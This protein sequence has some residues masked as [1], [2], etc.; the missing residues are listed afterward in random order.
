VSISLS[1]YVYPLTVE[2]NPNAGRERTNN[3]FDQ[4]LDIINLIQVSGSTGATVVSSGENISVVQSFSGIVPVYTVSVIDNPI[5]DSVSAN[6]ITANTITATTIFVSS[7]PSGSSIDVGYALSNLSSPPSSQI[8]VSASG[9]NAYS[10]TATPSITAYTINTIYLTQ[11]DNANTSTVT[12]I[13]I[14]S[15]GPL[16]ILKGGDSGLTSLDIGDI[17]TG[18]TYFLTYDG[19]EMQFFSS[20][21]TASPGTYTNLSPSTIAVGGIPI[22]TTFSSTTYTQ[23]FD[24]MFYPNLQ[25]A[26]TSFLL[27]SGTTAG[28]TASAFTQTQTLEVG[29]S[30][31]GGTKVFTWGTSNSSFVQTNSIK[32][33]NVT[34]GNVIISTPS[35]GISNS[36][37]AST[38][39]SNTKK[40]VQASHIW[41][42]Y[43]TKTP[44]L[45]TFNLSFQVNWF[46]RRMF[47]VSSTSALTT[48]AEVYAF[49]A[50]SSSTLTSTIIGTYAFSGAGYKYIFVPTTFASPTLFKDSSTNLSVAMAEI[51]DAPFFSGLSGSYYFG[52]T[53]VT[54]LFGITQN[55]RVY[56]TR[57]FLNGN[58]TIA[59]T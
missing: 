59:V 45:S 51:T 46:F 47:G 31:S 41:R 1:G 19:T 26:F 12:T 56:R 40:T 38:A 48:S 30:V 36:F 27:K 37:T 18:V 20:E 8:I 54:N 2:D 33:Y 58:I 52:T 32:I 10:G 14:D 13:D 24:A 9:T 15:L 28:D 7:V 29:D 6:T 11:F 17:Q 34:G 57:N 35:S 25:P 49:S 3:T 44:S 22:N 39:F 5:F 4:I 42:I 53:P 16:D 21:P 43:G 55:Y 23:L 50:S